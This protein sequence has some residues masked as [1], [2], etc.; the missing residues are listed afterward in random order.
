MVTLLPKK[1]K[2]TTEEG[3]CLAHW[4]LL[5]TLRVVLSHNITFTMKE[6]FKNISNKIQELSGASNMTSRRKAAREL[7]ESLAKPKIR[8]QLAVEAPSFDALQTVWELIVKNAIL[9]A[10]KI[11]QK[12]KEGMTLEDITVTFQIIQLSDEKYCQEVYQ[13][14][15]KHPAAPPEFSKYR[16]AFLLGNKITRQVL[17]FCLELLDDEAACAMAENQIL[18]FVASLVAQKGYLQSFKSEAEIQIVLEEMERRIVP[19]DTNSVSL[20][21]QVN[22]AEVVRNLFRTATREL[23]MDLALFVA[24]SIKMVALFAEGADTARQT[25]AVCLP[26]LEAIACLMRINPEQA[27]APLKR[28]GRA[29]LHYA[30]RAYRDAADRYHRDIIHEY[31]L[32]HLYETVATDGTGFFVCDLISHASFSFDSDSCLKLRG[33]CRAVYQ[34]IWGN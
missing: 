20:H 12:R 1:I 7:Y 26:L 31:F 25:Q 22:A 13:V 10:Q 14:A 19:A 23:G 21:V 4:F 30:K 2:A 11:H 29:I 17:N 8:Y 16:N 18:R 32:C 15:A 5:A 24:N 28:H 3:C 9:A 6:T 33:N 27:C 34:G